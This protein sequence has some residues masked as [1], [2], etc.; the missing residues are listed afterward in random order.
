MTIW[1][2]KEYMYMLD[3]N[4][5]LKISVRVVQCTVIS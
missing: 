3:M 5:H 1:S 2:Q 4:M